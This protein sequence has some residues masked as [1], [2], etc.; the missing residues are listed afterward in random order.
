MAEAAS[1]PRKTLESAPRGVKRCP[2]AD[3]VSLPVAAIFSFSED[4]QVLRGGKKTCLEIRKG[5]WKKNNAGK[6]KCGA[7]NKRNMIQNNTRTTDLGSIFA[8]KARN[9]FKAYFRAEGAKFF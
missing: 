1:T 8:P 4:T 7:R 2:T 5:V 6:N 3:R 9:F